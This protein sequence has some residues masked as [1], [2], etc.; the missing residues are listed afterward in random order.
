MTKINKR[1]N[2]AA[3]VIETLQTIP[4]DN[5]PKNITNSKGLL[6]GFL[7]RTIDSAPIIPKDKAIS[8]FIT[9]VM[10]NAIFGSNK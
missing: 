9:E 3:N 4:S 7:K 6:T 5:S 10:I 2:K 8:S 1:D